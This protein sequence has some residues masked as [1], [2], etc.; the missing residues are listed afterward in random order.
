MKDYVDSLIDT[1]GFIEIDSHAVEIIKSDINDFGSIS[2]KENSEKFE[3][4]IF[5]AEFR[6][7]EGNLIHMLASDC[8]EHLVYRVESE[9]ELNSRFSNSDSFTVRFYVGTSTVSIYRSCSN[10]ADMNFRKR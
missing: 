1:I 10:F 6:D 2:I 5:Q 9:I 8:I 7:L 3:K 4:Q